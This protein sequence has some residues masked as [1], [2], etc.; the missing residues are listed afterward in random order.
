MHGF[1]FLS[2]CISFISSLYCFWIT[3]VT[4]SGDD[5]DRRLK[6]REKNRVAAQ[7]SRKR[8]TQRADELHEV[9]SDNTWVGSWRKCL[10][11]TL[12]ACGLGL[13]CTVIQVWLGF[14]R[15]FVVLW[16]CGYGAKCMF[17]KN[18]YW[19]MCKMS[20]LSKCL[21]MQ[22]YECLQQQNSL[23]KKEVQLLL[24]EQRCL[25]EAL[26]LH[27]PQ[28]PVLNSS[29]L[30]TSRPSDG[31][32]SWDLTC[33]RCFSVSSRDYLRSAWVCVCMCFIQFGDYINCI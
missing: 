20:F 13:M 30:S 1:P 25:A 23:L 29:N 3:A 7:R 24:E 8:Q 27:E 2:D 5:D 22:A 10:W 28:C 18:Q 15:D 9:Q 31:T 6:R 14:G 17:K 26:K 32:R 16:V 19:F 21:S 11:G 4:Q 12:Y 33:T